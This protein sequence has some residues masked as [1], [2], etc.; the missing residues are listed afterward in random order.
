MNSDSRE[1][2]ERIL[3]NDVHGCSGFCG[4]SSVFAEIEISSSLRAS[5]KLASWKH[6][7]QRSKIAL[8]DQ[9]IKKSA[10]Q[11]SENGQVVTAHDPPFAAAIYDMLAVSIFSAQPKNQSVRSSM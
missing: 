6:N 2:C 10:G 11:K 4:D 5:T 9:H 8:L 3:L 1:T 7:F